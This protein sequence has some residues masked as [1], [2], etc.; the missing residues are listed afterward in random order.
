MQAKDEEATLSIAIGNEAECNVTVFSGECAPTAAD[1]L[2]PYL[3]L[4]VEG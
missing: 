3:V 1:T 2:P 4:R